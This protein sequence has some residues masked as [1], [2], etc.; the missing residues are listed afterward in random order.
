[1][2]TLDG[3]RHMGGAHHKTRVGLRYSFDTKNYQG[4]N[5]VALILKGDI[6]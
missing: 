2:I 4:Q 5:I 3:P 1:M 6:P